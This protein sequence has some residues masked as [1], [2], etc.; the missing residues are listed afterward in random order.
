MY[1]NIRLRRLHNILN[2][3][4]VLINVYYHNFIRDIN[5]LLQGYIR[6]FKINGRYKTCSAQYLSV[7]KEGV[8]K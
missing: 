8:V 4:N 3:D 5:N 2:I 7:E 1:S 6:H